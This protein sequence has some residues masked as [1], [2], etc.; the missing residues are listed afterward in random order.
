MKKPGDNPGPQLIEQPHGGALWQGGHPNPT[1]GPGRPPAEL[2][3]RMR[4][5]L[6][7]RLH[8]AEEIAD[9]PEVRPTDRLAA[10]AFLA[11]YGLGTVDDQTPAQQRFWNQQEYMLQLEENLRANPEACELLEQ[12]WD[13]A[14]P[15]GSALA[16]P[17]DPP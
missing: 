8:V 12:L 2:R 5:S 3:A 11:R 16:P 9:D 4:G 17:D 10:L 13:M 15:D 6:A 1:P 14:H 7:E